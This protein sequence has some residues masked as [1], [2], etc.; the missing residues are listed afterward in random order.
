[1]SPI[2]PWLLEILA[3]PRCHQKVE[4]VADGSGLRCAGCRLVY[5]VVDGIP[6]MLPESGRPEGEQGN[7]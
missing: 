3:C 4:P 5:P 7:S 2:E 6:Q 1:M